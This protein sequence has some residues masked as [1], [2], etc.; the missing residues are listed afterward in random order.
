TEVRFALSYEALKTRSISSSAQIS[1]IRFAIRQTNFS[2][3]IT[4]G[5]KTKTGRPPPIAPLPNRHG[6]ALAMESL[7]KAVCLS[8][9]RS[10]RPSH[11]R[12]FLSCFP[13]FIGNLF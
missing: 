9:Q 13:A 2:D 5:P 10:Q 4:H 6:F 12:P 7:R 8:F 3:S 11:R 1:A